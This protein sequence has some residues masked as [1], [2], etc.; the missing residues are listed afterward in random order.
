MIKL[1]LWFEDHAEEAA[2]FYTSVF[3]DSSMGVVSRFG[4]EGAEHHRQPIGKAMAVEF[5]ILNMEM[6]A[7]NGRRGIEFNDSASITVLCETQEEIDQYWQK[8]TEG[9][10]EGP[11][12]WLKDKFGVSWQITPKCL[13]EYLADSDPERRSR[14]ATAVFSMKKFNIAELVAAHGA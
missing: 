8:L 4:P 14:V 5:R 7:V 3:P 9:G 10:S 12:G 11:C 6:I 13:S 1:C 2:K